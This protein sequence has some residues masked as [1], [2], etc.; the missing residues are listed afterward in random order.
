VQSV[1]AANPPTVV[2]PAH[3]D[4]VLVDA[5]RRTAEVVKG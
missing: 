2:V 3:G 5:A 4:P 1:L